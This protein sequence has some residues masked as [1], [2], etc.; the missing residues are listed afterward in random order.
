MTVTGVPISIDLESVI[1]RHGTANPKVKLDATGVDFTQA[2]DGLLQ[3][4]ELVRLQP[5]PGRGLIFAAANRDEFSEAKYELPKLPNTSAED[6]KS[7]N[8]ELLIIIQGLLAPASWKLDQNPARLSF[9][10]SSLTVINSPSVHFQ[11]RELLAKVNAVLQADADSA[12]SDA[13]PKTNPL[14]TRT[15]QLA[16]KLD[17]PS[18][19]QHRFDEPLIDL[20]STLSSS[21][22]LVILADWEALSVEGWG[23]LTRIP[24]SLVGASLRDSLRELTQALGITYVIIDEGTILLTS[25]EASVQRTDLEVYSFKKLL[26]GKVNEEQALSILN[27]ALSTELKNPAIRSYYS[28]R[29][30]SLFVAAPQILQEKIAKILTAMEQL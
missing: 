15:A 4:A 26:K 24:G 18:G 16:E 17:A 13:D 28:K 6:R 29:F 12:H 20:L 10:D 22:G 9:A 7:V 8:D 19:L 25:F 27:H 30:Q 11:T 3:S 5:E 21:T 23:P 14:T 1:A 2:I